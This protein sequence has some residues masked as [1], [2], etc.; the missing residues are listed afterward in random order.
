MDTSVSIISVVGRV[1]SADQPQLSD[2]SLAE[3][4][5]LIPLGLNTLFDLSV[6]K[7]SPSP[8]LAVLPSSPSTA[9]PLLL[10]H[11]AAI[12][13]APLVVLPTPQMLSHA[14]GEQTAH[15]SVKVLVVHASLAEDVIE[16]VYEDR[17]NGIGILIVGD[18]NKERDYAVQDAKAHGLNVRY[19]EEIWEAAEGSKIKLPGTLIVIRPLD[20]LDSN[21]AEPTPTDIHSY[22]YSPGQNDNPEI[23]KVIHQVGNFTMP[24]GVRIFAEFH[25][26]LLLVLL[27]FSLRSRRINDPL[28]R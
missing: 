3:I 8:V 9:L 16:Q 14:L 12:P 27:A 5:R 10:L 24:F 22:F 23:V 18:P 2:E 17:Q 19:W 15:P 11:L 6:E 25:R 26:I 13:S 21:D 20:G 7:E 4:I 1:T 28:R